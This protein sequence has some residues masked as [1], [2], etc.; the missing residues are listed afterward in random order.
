MSKSPDS[1]WHNSKINWRSR[2]VK[3]GKIRADQVTPHPNNPRKHPIAQRQ[4]VEASFDVLGQIAPILINIRNGYLVDGEERTWLALSQG[5]ETELDV[6]W[7]DL[8]EEEHALALASFDWITQMAYYDRPI[9]ESLLEDIETDNA[10]LQSLLDDLAAA[11]DIDLNDTPLL[12]DQ[13]PQIDRAAELQEKWQV[14]RGDV[15]LI[16]SKTGK[17][18]HRLMCGDSTNAEDVA[19]LM[20]GV[21]ADAVITDPP[22]N[23][24]ME[25][26]D[27]DFDLGR[28]LDAATPFF[29]GFI[30]IFCQMPIMTLFVNELVSRKFIYKDC[31]V[32]LK[33]SLTTA[34]LPLNRCYENILLYAT[35]KT[36]RYVETKGFYSDIKLPLLDVGG[37]SINAIDRHIKDLQLT[38]KQGHKSLNPSSEQRN[39]A[40]SHMQGLSDRSPEFANFTNVWSFLPETL[41]TKNTGF[42]VHPT[43]KPILALVRLC[44]LLANRGAIVLDPFLG[45]GTTMIAAEQTGRVCYG[46]EISENYCAVILQRCADMGLSTRKDEV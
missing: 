34:A 2:I 19:R 32:W 17:G 41:I 38:V 9:L 30:A 39:K 22:Y 3:Y 18:V 29:S 20:G 4:A 45:S 11:N 35:D 13:G 15:W 43:M 5:D 26:W 12:E 37:I 10:A 21:K 25:E 24:N 31:I 8:S 23:L 16:D 7:I 40:Y 46:M 28:L 42:G 33:R 1:E 14:A 6:V 44:E 36:H 27:K